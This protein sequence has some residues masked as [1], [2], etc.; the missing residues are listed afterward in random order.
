MKAKY[1][2]INMEEYLTIENLLLVII[3]LL[4]YIAATIGNVFSK[5]AEIREETGMFKRRFIPKDEQ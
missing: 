4:V 1:K 2:G 5:V 3:F